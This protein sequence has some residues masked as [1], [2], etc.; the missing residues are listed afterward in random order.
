MARETRDEKADRLIDASSAAGAVISAG[1]VAA[2]LASLDRWKKPAQ[3]IALKN[4]LEAITRVYAAQLEGVVYDSTIYAYVLG[5][6]GVVAPL[7]YPSPA[8]ELQ[9]LVYPAPG[10]STPLGMNDPTRLVW[11]P[12]IPPPPNDIRF[13]LYP[14]GEYPRIEFPIIDKAIEQLQG[15]ATLTP[16]TYYEMAAAARQNAFTVSGSIREETIDQIRQILADNVGEISSRTDFLQQVRDELPD[17][18]LAEHHVEQVFRNNVNSAYSDGGEAALADPLVADAFPYR[19]YY[20]IHD[21][22]ARPEHLRL[23]RLGLDGTNVYHKND[24]VWLMFRPPW[25]WNCR[26]GWNPLSIRRAAAKGVRFAQQ[27]LETGIEPK[28]QFVKWPNFL[29]SASWQRVHPPEVAA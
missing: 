11:S 19:A 21:D 1:F 4:D 8:A 24:P 25:D 7:A 23:E 3:I 27:W 18:P 22:R 5:S 2:I 10:E 15:A 26:C 6:A 20:A 28:D 29:P 14:P 9:R 13:L 17:L 16:N 12:A